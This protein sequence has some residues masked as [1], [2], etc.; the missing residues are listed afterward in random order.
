ML[1]IEVLGIEL[2]QLKCEKCWEVNC[3]NWT[4]TTV[5]PLNVTSNSAVA[6]AAVAVIDPLGLYLYM[7]DQDQGG[8]YATKVRLDT[9]RQVGNAITLPAYAAE[10]S[11]HVALT[12]GGVAYVASTAAPAG[13]A[14]RRDHRRSPAGR[15]GRG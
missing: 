2:C 9:F 1:G 3:A 4:Q 5:L 14:L 15:P 8:T 13:V 7:F 11:P 12:A 10:S 6:G